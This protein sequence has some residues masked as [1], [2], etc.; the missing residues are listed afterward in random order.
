M[1]RLK[2]RKVQACIKGYTLYVN[3]KRAELSPFVYAKAHKDMVDSVFGLLRVIEPLG[4]ST[5]LRASELYGCLCSCGNRVAISRANLTVNK[6][7]SCGCLCG[8]KRRYLPPGEAAKRSVIRMYRYGAEKRGHVFDLSD[9]ELD[10]TF[11][12]NCYFCGRPP[13]N[14]QKSPCGDFTYSGIDCL[15]N[16]KG[17]AGCNVV[18]CCRVCNYAKSDMGVNEFIEWARGVAANAPVYVF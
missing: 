15:D 13:S 14:I 8:K 10:M 6:V 12:S 9:A 7:Q 5:Q 18:P 16:T 3:K 4:L 2:T 17:Y 11:K 1:S